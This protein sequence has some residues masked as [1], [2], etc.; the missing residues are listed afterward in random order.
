[1]PGLQGDTRAPWRLAGAAALLAG[2]PAASA[3]AAEYF[4]DPV[5]R[6]SA[7]YESNPRLANTN[8]RDTAGGVL[9]VSA[10][11]GARSPVSLVSVAPRFQT[12][13][14]KEDSLDRTDRL[15]DLTLERA[16]SENLKVGLTGLASRLSTLVSEADDTGITGRRDRDRYLV[17]PTLSWQAGVR[18]RFG[19]TYSY[20]DTSYNEGET[21]ELVDYDYQVVTLVWSRQWT[22]LTEGYSEVFASEYGNQEAECTTESLGGRLGLNVKLSPTFLVG[23]SA[24]YVTSDTDFESFEFE[25][26]VE[27]LPG[28]EV[29]PAERQTVDC[30][31]VPA[32][33]IN[34]TG[35]VRDSTDNSSFLASVKLQQKISD[36]AAVTT[37]FDRSVA[38]SGRGVQTIRDRVSITW[39]QSLS[40]RV[41]FSLGGNYQTNES[42]VEEGRARG[43]TRDT[44]QMSSDIRYR[45]SEESF[46]GIGYR[47]RHRKDDDGFANVDGREAEN[48]TALVFFDYDLKSRT[49][50][51]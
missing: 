24:G 49:L 18:D 31:Q 20:E 30:R 46:V 47:Y 4:V 26:P 40:E 19:L 28:E 12:Y 15:V 14:Y 27:P 8:E 6:I 50:L 2:I 9:D 11:F 34:V 42:D 22:Q 45:L 16:L 3:V 7:L 37:G 48:H 10:E 51:R 5:V 25:V 43:R 13:R 35:P 21:R 33:A 23:G 32:G 29:E 39:T 36:I 17:S 1:M 38:A 44:I 41:R